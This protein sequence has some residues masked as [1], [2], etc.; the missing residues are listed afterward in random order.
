V[1]R[2]AREGKNSLVAAAADG[3]SVGR[4]QPVPRRW[5]TACQR[6]RLAAWGPG[7][8]S[9]PA[10]EREVSPV[11]RSVPSDGEGKRSAPSMQP[12]QRRGSGAPRDS[13]SGAAGRRRPD[14]SRQIAANA[15]CVRVVG[16]DLPPSRP[17]DVCRDA[18]AGY[19]WSREMQ[20]S[21]CRG[22]VSKRR[23]HEVVYH[24]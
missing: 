1:S 6:G 18:A 8:D 13:L 15:C 2:G 17:G 23:K 20:V 7:S 11:S 24:A 22:V 3:G 9:E 4:V 14:P 21:A 12:K 19:G 5:Q 10:D 16:M